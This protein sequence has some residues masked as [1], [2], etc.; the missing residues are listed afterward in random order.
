MRFKCFNLVFENEFLIDK[1]EVWFNGIE[2]RVEDGDSE[3]IEVLGCE[4]Y[5]IFFCSIE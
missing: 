5:Y 2:D 1:I 4:V 3:F